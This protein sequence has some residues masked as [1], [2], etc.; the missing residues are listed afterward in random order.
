MDKFIRTTG[1]CHSFKMNVKEREA[2]DIMHKIRVYNCMPG[3][4]GI[5]IRTFGPMTHGGTD[6]AIVSHASLSANELKYLVALLSEA[7][8]TINVKTD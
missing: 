1:K 6:H 7:I 4:V 8:A 3:R 5:Q 2:E